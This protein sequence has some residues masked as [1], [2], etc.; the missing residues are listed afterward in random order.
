MKGFKHFGWFV[1]LLCVLLAG[2]TPKTKGVGAFKKTGNMINDA[3]NYST[4]RDVDIPVIKHR[5]GKVSIVDKYN[6]RVPSCWGEKVPGVITRIDSQDKI[7]ALTFDACGGKNGD[8]YDKELIDY[9][10]RENIPASLFINSRWIDENYDIFMKLAGNPLFEIENHGDKHKPL[11]VNGKSAYNI[12]GTKN[13]KE[14]VDEVQENEQ[15]IQKLTGRRPRFFR[16]GTAYYDDVAAGI[17]RDLGEEPVNFSIIGDAGAT[18]NKEQVNKACLKA[19]PGDIIIFHM[20][21]P[22]KGTAKGIM[23]AVPELRKRGF[24]FVKLEDYEDNLK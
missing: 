5:V 18:Y 2:C 15:K 23:M 4:A 7:I 11:S 12:D 16:S 14:I 17:V 13:V 6:G 19:R 9:L 22:G 8:G 3:P 1:I 21:H 20:N 24:Q 10:I